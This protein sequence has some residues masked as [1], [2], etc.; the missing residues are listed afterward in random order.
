[1]F[2]LPAADKMRVVRG[3]RDAY[4]CGSPPRTNLPP[5]EELKDGRQG[6]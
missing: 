5:G 6:I 2:A 3:P 4:G 1:M